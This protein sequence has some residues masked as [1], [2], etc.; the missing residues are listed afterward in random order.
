MRAIIRQFLLMVKLEQ[1]SLIQL[2]GIKKKVSFSYVFKI[3]LTA[4]KF[5]MIKKGSLPQ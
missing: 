4:K 1:E 2:K 5:R 3:F